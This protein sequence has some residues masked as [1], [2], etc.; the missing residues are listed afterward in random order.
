MQLCSK[1]KGARR[2]EPD[3]LRRRGQLLSRP[4]T[5]GR[6]DDLTV[7]VTLSLSIPVIS[8]VNPQRASVHLS[9]CV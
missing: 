8:H 3:I 5:T 2:M 9:T 7:P 4:P 1:P 6:I